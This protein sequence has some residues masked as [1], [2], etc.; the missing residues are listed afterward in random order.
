MGV[1]RAYEEKKRSEEVA[2]LKRMGEQLK[3]QLDMVTGS[4]K[5]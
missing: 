3:R 1:Y 4:S 5:K 2:Y